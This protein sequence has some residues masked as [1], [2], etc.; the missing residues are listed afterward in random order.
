[1]WRTQDSLAVSHDGSV[2]YLVNAS[3][4]LRSQTLAAPQLRPPQGT[5]D[6]PIRGVLLSTAELDH[7]LGL[8][9]MREARTLEVHASPTV[10]EALAGPLPMRSTLAAYT[11][12][13]WR[14]LADGQPTELLGGLVVTR[15]TLAAK[16]P[17]YAAGVDGTEW[18]SALEVTDGSGGRL[19]YATCL[20]AWNHTLETLV[21]Q[22]SCVVLDGTF[23]T[24][25]E[26]TQVTGSGGRARAMGHLSMEDSWPLAGR[27]RARV[28]YSHVNNTNPLA[29]SPG[30]AGVH[31]PGAALAGI[32]VAE[33]GLTL[34]L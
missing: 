28:L 34:I 33:D 4:D 31:V 11:D 8:M 32:E 30:A 19:V 6:T 5:R 25:D 27:L 1:M 10:L 26:L 15:W 29:V 18:V 14:P 23:A 13:S 22:A 21:A 3:P 16:R 20:P 24:D 17:R 7:T 9:T 12:I 2:W